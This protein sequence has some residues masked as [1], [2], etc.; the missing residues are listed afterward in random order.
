MMKRLIA[1]LVSLM[2]ITACDNIDENN[3][4][5]DSGKMDAQKRVLLEDFTGQSCPNCPTAALIATELQKASNGNLIVVSIHA[6]GL[7]YKQFRT[8]EGDEYLK[9]FYSDGDEIGYPAGMIDRSMINGNRV[10]TEYHKWS[11][12]I[13][14]RYQ[15]KAKVGLQ[16]SCVDDRNSNHV[17][18]HTTLEGISAGDEP[19]RLQLWLIESG[20]VSWQSVAS[21][22]GSTTT[23][24]SYIHNHVFRESIN[25]V[26]GEDIKLSDGEN[27]KKQ[28]NFTLDTDKYNAANCQIVAFVYNSSTY[29]VYQSAE[30]NLL[31]K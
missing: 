27:L 23:N 26:W 6:G 18:I 17:V 9:T 19:L 13:T 10:S 3:R 22:D 30:C 21:P 15:E 25:G 14:D 31:N 7:S 12:Y 8:A 11:S 5:K 4:Y 28:N 24:P 2:L 20:I 29:E 1:A 16:V